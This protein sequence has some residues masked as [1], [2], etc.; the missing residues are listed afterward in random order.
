MVLSVQTYGVMIQFIIIICYGLQVGVVVPILV[1]LVRVLLTS[2][3]SFSPAV[4]HVNNIV[5]N[6]TLDLIVSI[7]S[8]CE[9]LAATLLPVL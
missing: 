9:L 5:H 7:V 1:C 3:L 6:M 8:V 2:L 4:Q